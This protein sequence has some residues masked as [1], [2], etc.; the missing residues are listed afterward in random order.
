MLP[1]AVT[2]DLLDHLCTH[3]LIIQ[4][5]VPNKYVGTLNMFSIVIYGW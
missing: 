2:L 3:N 5:T 1:D 4:Y